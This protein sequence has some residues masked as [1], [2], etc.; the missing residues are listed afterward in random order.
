MYSRFARKNR[1]TIPFCHPK[2]FLWHI[3]LFKMYNKKHSKTPEPQTAKRKKFRDF[4]GVFGTPSPYTREI[5][6]DDEYSPEMFSQ[7]E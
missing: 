5:I 1:N 3:P 2:F 4:I 7:S 6:E